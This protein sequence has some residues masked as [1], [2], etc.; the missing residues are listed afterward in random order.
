MTS[1]NE[2]KKNE[3][4]WPDNL[5]SKEQG[6]LGWTPLAKVLPSEWYRFKLG[7]ECFATL[8]SLLTWVRGTDYK[9]VRYSQAAI[10]RQQGVH[11]NTINRQMKKMEGKFFT[12]VDRDHISFEP[13]MEKLSL[14]EKERQFQA[15]ER[16]ADERLGWVGLME[17][18]SGRP[19]HPD[20][21]GPA[22][23][24]GTP[25]YDSLY[26]EEGVETPAYIAEFE[27]AAGSSGGR[28]SV[29]Q[30]H[31]SDAQTPGTTAPL[32]T[33]SASE[34]R[35]EPSEEAFLDHFR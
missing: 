2:T 30:S 26:A 25:S 34:S 5:V 1:N 4:F 28:E 7:S 19:R 23:K 32:E 20:Q 13:L 9:N 24:F 22:G 35:G 27:S 15:A 31:E 12:Y 21:P 11:R 6:A 18:R 17:R 3:T 8:V 29:A 16:A 33:P 14:M 10:G